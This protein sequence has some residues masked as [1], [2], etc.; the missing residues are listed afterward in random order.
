MIN[1][2]KGEELW[3]LIK[4]DLIYTEIDKTVELERNRQLSAPSPCFENRDTVC[5]LMAEGKFGELN[6]QYPLDR[7]KHFDIHDITAKIP[8]VIKK[9]VFYVLSAV[10]RFIKNR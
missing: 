8:M 1:S 6:K 9:P 10:Y 4:D 3:D 2:D 7:K 5:R